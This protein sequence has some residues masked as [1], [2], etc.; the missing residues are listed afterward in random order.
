[1]N[2]QL[3]EVIGKELGFIQF[4]STLNSQVKNF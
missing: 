4:A 1:M 3:I 2:F